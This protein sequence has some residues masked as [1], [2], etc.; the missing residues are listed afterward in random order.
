[1][2]APPWRRSTAA[3]MLAG[4]NGDCSSEPATLHRVQP[5]GALQLPMAVV[6]MVSPKGHQHDVRQHDSKSLL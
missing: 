2:A 6:S 4:R 1:M 3:V 5:V